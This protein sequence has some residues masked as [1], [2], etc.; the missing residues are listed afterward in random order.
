M[1]G[2]DS[3]RV[4]I[5]IPYDWVTLQR[6]DM[7]AAQRWRAITNRLLD[8]YLGSQPGR[9]FITGTGI[10]GSRCYLIGE[11][12]D[13]RLLDDLFLPAEEEGDFPL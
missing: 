11:R 13:D 3:A 8:H 10:S 12:V 2:A 6:Q 1:F 9:Y 7:P 5:E 4:A